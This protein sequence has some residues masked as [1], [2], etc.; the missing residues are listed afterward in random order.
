MAD[1]YL[2]SYLKPGAALE[3]IIPRV[4]FSELWLRERLLSRRRQCGGTLNFSGL[5]WL[6]KAC[7]YFS[8]HSVFR[9]RYWNEGEEGL[10]VLLSPSSLPDIIQRTNCF[11]HRTRSDLCLSPKLRLQ[12]YDD[13]FHAYVLSFWCH[14]V[15]NSMCGCMR[16]KHLGT[17]SPYSLCTETGFGRDHNTR[18]QATYSQRNGALSTSAGEVLH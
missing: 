7:D 10:K 9:W 17:D 4:S 12:F 3:M 6:W 11:C 15:G 13:Y 2:E 1:Y 14:W 18:K 5:L 16:W 8:T